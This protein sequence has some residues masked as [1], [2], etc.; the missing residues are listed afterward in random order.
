VA[1]REKRLFH[2]SNVLR[3]C[4]KTSGADIWLTKSFNA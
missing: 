3:P 4:E 2:T 1:K